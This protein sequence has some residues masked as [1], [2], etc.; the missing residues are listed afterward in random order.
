MK[1]AESAESSFLNFLVFCIR[2][3]LVSQC[4]INYLCKDGNKCSKTHGI[5]FRNERE[6]LLC[7]SMVKVK[8]IGPRAL[9]F[10]GSKSVT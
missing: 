2:L 10:V 9:T 1:V 4:I 8:V 3:C 6:E 5:A 7:F